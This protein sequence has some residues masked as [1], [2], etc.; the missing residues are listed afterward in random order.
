LY[1]LLFSIHHSLFTVHAYSAIQDQIPILLKSVG[2]VS[3][4]GY[5][6]DD[7]EEEEFDNE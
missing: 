2:E 1:Y 3:Q 7:E 6:E 4:Y 5:D